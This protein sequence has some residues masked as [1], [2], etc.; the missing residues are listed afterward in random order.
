MQ[1]IIG[2]GLLSAVLAFFVAVGYVNA[3]T[4]TT[5]PTTSPTPTT[6]TTQ[7]QNTPGTPNT[8]F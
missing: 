3:Q 4:A 7:T 8:G 6:S 2:I 5:S 1:K